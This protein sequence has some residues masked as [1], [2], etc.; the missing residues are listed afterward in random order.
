MI[1]RN[2]V[3]II[4]AP[5]F[6]T[7]LGAHLARQEMAELSALLLTFLKALGKYLSL[8]HISEPTRPY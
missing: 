3:L 6:Q 2:V 1:H 8:I 5:A 7:G 4:D